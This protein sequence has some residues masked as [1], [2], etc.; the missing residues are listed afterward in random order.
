MQQRVA[1]VP[2]T[3]CAF[4]AEQPISHF[5]RWEECLLP[6]CSQC[7]PIHRREHSSKKAPMD[8]VTIEQ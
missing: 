5:C 8:I 2:V 4:H 7:L 1:V 6:L 3:E